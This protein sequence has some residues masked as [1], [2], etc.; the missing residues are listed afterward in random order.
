MNIF[1]GNKDAKGKDL[2]YFQ[3]PYL[4]GGL[5]A[6]KD[7]ELKLY[8]ALLEK[9]NRNTVVDVVAD[10][11]EIHFLCGIAT[12]SVTTA[13]KG[14]EFKGL[15]RSERHA[16]G[17]TYTLL[18]PDTRAP[19]VNYNK[20]GGGSG[21]YSFDV[22]EL[23]PAQYEAYFRHHLAGYQVKEGKN[24]GRPGLVACCPFHEDSN[25]SLSISLT[26]GV[27]N[28]RGACKIGGTVFEFEQ[29]I[30]LKRNREEINGG[31]AS[32]R[33]RE[34]LRS[35]GLLPSAVKSAVK[36]APD[37]I[38]LYTD[39]DGILL[40]EV[41][42]YGYGKGKKFTARRPHPINDG[43]YIWDT[44]GVQT[45]PYRLP[46]V[47]GAAFS[48]LVV[49]GERKADTL[50][51]LNLHD[52]YGMPIAATCNPF[53]AGSWKDDH[54]KWLEDREVIILPD[55]DKPGLE[56]AAQV[57]ESLKRVASVNARIVRLPVEAVEAGVNDVCDYLEKHTREELV[58]LIGPDWF[59]PVHPF[60]EQVE[61]VRI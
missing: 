40:F 53:G 18:N 1:R 47:R 11:A 60:G 22:R 36:A 28:C 44:E 15:I 14:L 31:E 19:M 49:E 42:R 45:V 26:K 25:P 33:V 61:Q 8:L 4:L 20:I 39:L 38:Y 29:Q 46:E 32:K 17:F 24:Y 37:E 6:W 56:H 21:G 23:T 54:S 41:W 2:A 27:W 30:A 35:K 34:I 43:E 57:Q 48:V 10:N 52:Q 51:K 3:F 9:A 5:S 58:Q 13:R 50:C 59:S 55:M 7:C 12:G 16:R